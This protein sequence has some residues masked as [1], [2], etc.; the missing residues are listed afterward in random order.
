ME[1]ERERKQREGVG[2]V[3]KDTTVNRGRERV[4]GRV[5]FSHSKSMRERKR[6]RGWGK[7]R[8]KGLKIEKCT[9]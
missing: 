1:R 7:G 4:W 8:K 5:S 2:K 3:S 9:K 6:R